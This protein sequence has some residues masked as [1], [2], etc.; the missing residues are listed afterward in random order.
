M[1]TPSGYL[2]F[3][4]FASC[5][6]VIATVFTTNAGIS[7]SKKFDT[8]EL[9]LTSEVAGGWHLVRTPNPNGGNDAL[10][11]MHTADTARSDLNL[12]GLMIRCRKGGT[13]AA[14]VLLSAFPLRT[15]LQVVLGRPQNEIKFDATVAPP[16]TVILLPGDGKTLVNGSWKALSELFIRVENDRTVTHGVVALTGLKVAFKTL[17]EGC[18]LL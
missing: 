18:L 15:R 17:V 12:A 10:S 3:L 16:G 8:V 7:S 4:L 6:I 5:C 14:V 13:E 1:K 11:I 2:S 9:E